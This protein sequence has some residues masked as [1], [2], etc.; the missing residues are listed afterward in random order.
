MLILLYLDEKSKKEFQN[1]FL[2]LVIG[3][4]LENKSSQELFSISYLSLF[5]YC[6]CLHETTT[7]D[8]VKSP[9]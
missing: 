6:R 3:Q 5:K 4:I 2:C 9:T 8:I 1:K 7:C